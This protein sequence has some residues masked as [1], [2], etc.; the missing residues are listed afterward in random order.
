MND[1]Q[2]GTAVPLWKNLASHGP[3]ST[4]WLRAGEQPQY[5]SWSHAKVLPMELRSTA[6]PA[7]TVQLSRVHILRCRNWALILI[8]WQIRWVSTTIVNWPIDMDILE[9][10][11]LICQQRVHYQTDLERHLYDL[12]FVL[13]DRE[14]LGAWSSLGF[15]LPQ[16]QEKSCLISQKKF[17]WVTLSA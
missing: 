14:G 6:K 3:Y 11:S 10:V 17:C 7:F 13:W 8:W 5:S 1:V 9:S 12:Q 2:E 15:Y 16:A 4:K